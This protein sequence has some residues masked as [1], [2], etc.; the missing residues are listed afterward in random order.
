RAP[1]GVAER[2]DDGGGRD[3]RRRLPDALH[4]VGRVG[5]R[6]LD[7][8]ADHRRHVERRRDQVVGEARVRDQAV[9]RLDLLHQREA[10]PLGRPALDLTGDRLRVDRPADVLRRAD[11]DH[12]REPEVDVDLGDDPHG[13]DRE[14]DVRALAGGLAGLGV[15]GPGPRVVVDALGVDLRGPGAPA[16]LESGPAREPDDATLAVPAGAIATSSSSSSVRATW[17]I[18]PSTPWPTSAAAQWISAESPRRTTLAAQK[19][20]KPS[21]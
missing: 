17:R 1:G 7:Q 15:E 19:S 12:A 20:S 10:E 6:V 2:R 5:L 4:A 8:L 14:R 3:D 9:A 18:T 11:P 16:L 21:E 13:G